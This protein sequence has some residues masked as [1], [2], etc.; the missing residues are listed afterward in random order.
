[1]LLSAISSHANQTHT[2]VVV[3]LTYVVPTT[4]YPEFCYKTYVVSQVSS[5]QPT[6]NP[7]HAT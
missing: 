6:Q 2:Y 4:M 3:C 5:R 1:M 7:E